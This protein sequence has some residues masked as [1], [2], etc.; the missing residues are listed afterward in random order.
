MDQS[1]ISNCKPEGE[2]RRTVDFAHAIGKETADD[3]AD[4]HTCRKGR[5]HRRTRRVAV[6][7]VVKHNWDVLMTKGEGNC[8]NNLSPTDNALSVA[9]KRTPCGMKNAKKML[10]TDKNTIVNVKFLK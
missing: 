1:Q 10:N 9:V 6:P 2:K 5:D 8:Q 4:G 3:P 7:A